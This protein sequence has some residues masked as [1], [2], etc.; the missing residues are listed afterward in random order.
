MEVRRLQQELES[1][2][3]VMTWTS[4]V[5]DAMS[6]LRGDRRQIMPICTGCKLDGLGFS[7][8]GVVSCAFLTV[9][10]LL[11]QR[12]IQS[13]STMTGLKSIGVVVV[14]YQTSIYM[15]SVTIYTKLNCSHT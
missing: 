3:T 15:F 10:C 9:S 7:Y 5:L 12:W 14:N 1:D 8:M 13:T 11:F 4:V 6:R 2:N